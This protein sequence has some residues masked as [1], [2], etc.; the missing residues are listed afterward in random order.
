MT[1]YRPSDLWTVSM[2]RILGLHVTLFTFFFISR[3]RIACRISRFHVSFL[4]PRFNFKDK[5]NV[6]YISASC[7]ILF[8]LFDFA[9][10]N[11]AQN[12]CFFYVTFY[13]TSS[14]TRTR[15][16]WSWTSVLKRCASREN[17]NTHAHSQ[18]RVPI[19]NMD[20]HLTHGL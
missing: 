18:P 15:I 8:I 2:R 14:I 19:T 13:S 4:F 16:M 3:T 12:F 1:F 6:Q 20:L 10:D 9:D 5:N 11:H 17:T 7:D